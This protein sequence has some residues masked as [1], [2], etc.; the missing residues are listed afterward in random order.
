M[1]RPQI[2]DTQDLVLKMLMGFA[3]K[4][5]K[6]MI[7]DPK[8]LTE[9]LS[10]SYVK[11]PKVEIEIGGL[12]QSIRPRLYYGE[13]F[14][15]TGVYETFTLSPERGGAALELTPELLANFSVAF[16]QMAKDNNINLAL[17]NIVLPD[18]A[19]SKVRTNPKV[20]IVVPKKVVTARIDDMTLLEEQRQYVEADN[21]HLLETEM[22]LLL[23][24]EKLRK[25]FQDLVVVS[26]NAS[27]I[28]KLS[29]NLAELA[30][31]ESY[32]VDSA[33]YFDLLYQLE[34]VIKT[35]LGAEAKSI[36][37]LNDSQKIITNLVR[38]ITDKEATLLAA[39]EQFKKY[40]KAENSILGGS[41]IGDT[42]ERESFNNAIYFREKLFTAIGF[43][44]IIKIED[45]QISEY[46]RD[47]PNVVSAYVVGAG[48]Q[49]NAAITLV[50]EFLLRS[51]N[52]AKKQE[53]LSGLSAALLEEGVAQE[54]R[55]EMVGQLLKNYALPQYDKDG[56]VIQNIA[57]MFCET[58][59][60]FYAPAQDALE[61]PPAAIM[62]MVNI[63]AQEC[64]RQSV[65]RTES[66]D[67]AAKQVRE[68]F[69]RLT[70]PSSQAKRSFDTDVVTLQKMFERVKVEPRST[71]ALMLTEYANQL[72]D[73]ADVLK[74]HHEAMDKAPPLPE[75]LPALPQAEINAL[76]KSFALLRDDAAFKKVVSNLE[77]VESKLKDAYTHAQDLDI[78]A[79]PLD[80]VAY[81]A[82][83]E[84]VVK[85]TVA[86]VEDKKGS[87]FFGR[88]NL[89]LGKVSKAVGLRG[90]AS[91][92]FK[93][94]M[95]AGSEVGSREM[96]EE[97]MRASIANVEDGLRAGKSLAL[98]P[99]FLR[100]N[101]PLIVAAPKD[102][103]LSVDD[104]ENI[105]NNRREIRQEQAQEKL[106]EV[107]TD[108]AL[109]ETLL[110]DVK[111]LLADAQEQ[112]MELDRVAPYSVNKASSGY[113]NLLKK[114]DSNHFVR[115]QEV[116]GEVVDVKLFKHSKMR[117]VEVPL[118]DE[119]GNA[120]AENNQ[121]L[122]DLLAK[123]REYIAGEKERIS[124]Q[125]KELAAQ[126]I[127]DAASVSDEARLAATALMKDL[128]NILEEPGDIDDSKV[129]ALPTLEIA[130]DKYSMA[131]NVEHPEDS[132]FSKDGRDFDV[133][134]QAGL[135]VLS[136]YVRKT[137]AAALDEQAKQDT[138]S[139]LLEQINDLVVDTKQ[140]GLD[141]RMITESRRF[142]SYK[143]FLKND[144]DN[145]LRL[146][147]DDEG[148]VNDVKMF[149]QGNEYLGVVKT[150][151]VEIPLLNEEGN[152]SKELQEILVR[153]SDRIS[154]AKK[155]VSGIIGKAVAMVGEFIEENRDELEDL[156]IDREMDEAVEGYDR[157]I[158]PFTVGDK[159]YSLRFEREDPEN[160][161]LVEGDSQ[162][163][164]SLMNPRT[165]DILDDFLSEVKK[166]QNL[167][168]AVDILDDFLIE[169]K[170]EEF[171][172]TKVSSKGHDKS[173]GMIEV[174]GISYSLRFEAA[175]TANL[176]LLK[177]ED[178]ERSVVDLASDEAGDILGKYFAALEEN[179]ALDN[180]AELA[181]AQ[182][183][184]VVVTE[185]AETG[186]LD[187]VI[188]VERRDSNE[189]ILE[190][191]AIDNVS[192]DSESSLV[193]TE[194]QDIDELNKE[195]L[196]AR[197]QEQF[198]ELSKVEGVKVETSSKR[199]FGITQKFP[200]Q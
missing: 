181:T 57:A 6:S 92:C 125:A 184:Q 73:L 183:V 103:A 161:E 179:L 180:E 137:K 194:S 51:G 12:K 78:A 132:K 115:F 122:Q 100:A 193:S 155:E 123:H 130:K 152:V 64:E 96:V 88:L 175:N 138:T 140:Y 35:E 46:L 101:M 98:S 199:Q 26:P 90:F 173:L 33:E 89:G 135:A 200:L 104:A 147:F 49:A 8:R 10:A 53:F 94:A 31:L 129:I 27:E 149:R 83:K 134:S 36:T 40:V 79:R 156:K 87:S 139:D 95:Q 144:T 113:R 55:Y 67:Y 72:Q 43:E 151:A 2:T 169:N 15:S 195:S 50:G 145:Y 60:D 59:L 159:E 116:D 70:A 165:I 177:F 82:R 166:E 198:G 127:V 21:V 102:T 47:R 172:D 121:L 188:A 133:T 136:A 197:L 107:A 187:D 148:K 160:F 48:A 105:V 34:E 117:S 25:T 163:A 146:G 77:A 108:I 7:I 93:R 190:N 18:P 54:S 17:P 39:T 185:E 74:L 119:S 178:G 58:A 68:K 30:F 114:N 85:S 171:R 3:Y 196:I 158:G 191:D 20:S 174:D 69:E 182:A 75:V 186:D 91:S 189:S 4:A 62:G 153:A 126:A 16:V 11:L 61:L 28:A 76:K 109:P 97:A 37:P 157:L 71:T 176:R 19:V 192:L 22:Q 110:G 56:E 45:A 84:A 164:L 124:T 23:G 141:S 52:A 66:V 80:E 111:N 168:M 106:T 9:L 170:D 41:R 120:I 63:F 29:P 32:R 128:A 38:K 118:L 131:F 86:L 65:L 167:K 44:G 162:R 81:Q 42:L 1:S 5:P 14:G 13:N 143:N 112:G 142:K 99:G 24:G 154:E 150:K